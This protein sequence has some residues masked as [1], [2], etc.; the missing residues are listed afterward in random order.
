MRKGISV[1]VV[2][3]MLLVAVWTFAGQRT[4]IVVAANDKSLTA[5]VSD[6]A[7]LSQY[8]FFFD[9]KGNLIEAV[10]NPFKEKHGEAGKLLADFLPEKGVT[11]FVGDDFCGEIV[12]VFKNK[13]IKPVNFKGTVEEAV[14]M[15]LKN[16]D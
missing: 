6:K 16:L 8:F 4:L 9:E 7:G 13:G 14:R 11:V 15:V 2:F 10:D 12:D 3:A 5:P 1:M